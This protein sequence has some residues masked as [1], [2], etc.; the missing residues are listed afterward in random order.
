MC[1]STD[2]LIRIYKNKKFTENNSSSI[3]L[4]KTKKCKVFPPVGRFYHMG[5]LM[6]PTHMINGTHPP[7]NIL[8]SLSLSFV[9]LSSP[10]VQSCAH[11]SSKVL[12]N[13]VLVL[14]ATFVP[15]SAHLCRS[16]YFPSPHWCQDRIMSPRNH[17]HFHCRSMT[18]LPWCHWIIPCPYVC[19][20]WSPN[21]MKPPST[22]MSP[23]HFRGIPLSSTFTLWSPCTCGNFSWDFYHSSSFIMPTFSP[24]Y[25]WSYWTIILS[26]SRR[27][28]QLFTGMASD[29]IFRRIHLGRGWWHLHIHLPFPSG[30]FSLHITQLYIY[31]IFRTLKIAVIFSLVSSSNSVV[32]TAPPP[33]LQ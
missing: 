7:P 8:L 22:Q 18:T 6:F 27:A 21:N 12:Q 31:T 13:I 1:N 15:H 23:P 32:G 4:F 5:C 14:V 3:I 29:A 24:V 19:P 26:L 30:W 16:N 9:Y 28:Y 10:Y 2:I 20:Y 11:T 25:L 17:P 33:P